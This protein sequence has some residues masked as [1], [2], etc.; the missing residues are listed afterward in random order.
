MPVEVQSGQIKKEISG[1]WLTNGHLPACILKLM[2]PTD[3]EWKNDYSRPGNIS[4]LSQ[5]LQ[6]TE[7]REKSLL[8]C[9]F[10]DYPSSIVLAPELA[11]GSPDFDAIDA[12]IKQYEQ[13]LIFICGFGFTTGNTLNTLGAKPDV[14]G[15]W[16]T[17]PNAN[18]KYNGGWV[19][20]KYGDT[21][22]CYILLKNYLEQNNEITVENI[23][24]GDHILRLEGD[25]IIIFPLICADLI[26]TEP[27][28]PS[29]RIAAS[30]NSD[31]PAN[32]KVL[33][34]VS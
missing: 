13:N 19:W 9:E 1:N 29:N 5:L 8:E 24:T 27:Q 25:D 18:K 14:E 3:D 31:S 26:S 7:G 11:F 17:S 20:I 6:P 33:D 2:S 12:L 15:I 34:T 30:L 16:N 28:S 21:V 22:Q 4:I 10:P 23:T 32:K